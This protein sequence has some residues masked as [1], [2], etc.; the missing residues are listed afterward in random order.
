MVVH[1]IILATFIVV[2]IVDLSGIVDSIKEAIGRWLKVKVNRIKPLDCSLC[3]T[4][5]VGLIV[6]LAEG[7]F[8]FPMVSLVCL[9]A[10]LTQPLKGALILLSDAI[11]SFLNKINEKI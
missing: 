8:S 2:F 5:W 11:T 7:E 9:C 6:L 4:F 10:Y 1:D 3:M